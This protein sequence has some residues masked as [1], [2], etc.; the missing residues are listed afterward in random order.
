MNILP[1]NSL[2]KAI[3]DMSCLEIRHPK[4]CATVEHVAGCTFA[5]LPGE[6]VCVTGPSRVGKTTATNEAICSLAPLSDD[7][8]HTDMPIVRVRLRN[9]TKG[10]KFDS[11]LFIKSALAAIEHPIYGSPEPD[12]E[13]GATFDRRM[14][15]VSEDILTSAFARAVEARRTKYLIIDE[16][17]HLL[18]APKGISGALAI[19]DSWKAFA[20]ATGVVLILIGTYPILDILDLSPHMLGRMSLVEFSRYRE[21]P[22]EIAEFQRILNT[23]DELVPMKDSSLSSINEYLYRGTMGCVGLL[24]RWVRDSMGLSLARG[25]SFLY[26]GALKEHRQRDTAITSIADEIK[27]GEAAIRSSNSIVSE[28]LDS[29]ASE[30]KQ[31]HRNKR[32]DSRPFQSKARNPKQGVR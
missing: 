21:N 1:H 14:A 13:F 22:E 30:G 15:K 28:D 26:V 18:H 27:K 19:L 6:I 4:Y 32:S 3:S 8:R 9:S 12:D 20:E 25:N 23:L 29:T 11:K 7:I 16:S 31:R 17:Q 24:L 10:G 5:T 2:R